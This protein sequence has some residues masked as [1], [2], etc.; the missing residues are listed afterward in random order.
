[1]RFLEGI[2]T[3]DTA[4]RVALR[5]KLQCKPFQWFLDEV[6]LNTY[7]PD[8]DP[9]PVSIKVRLGAVYCWRRVQ[10]LPRPTKRMPSH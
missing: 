3:G 9:H 2:D 5:H 7:I 10:I 4:S 8:L 6:C 1:M